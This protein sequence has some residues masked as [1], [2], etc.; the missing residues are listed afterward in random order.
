MEPDRTPP[1]ERPPDVLPAS[2]FDIPPVRTHAKLRRFR[3]NVRRVLLLIGFIIVAT[4]A[5]NFVMAFSGNPHFYEAKD[6]DR[7][8]ETLQKDIQKLKH[9]LGGGR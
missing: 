1:A 8:L 6:I 3:H 7:E 4:W 9:Q 2:N 5:L